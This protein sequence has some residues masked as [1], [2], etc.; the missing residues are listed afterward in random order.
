M[1][2]CDD[3]K[4]NPE[5]MVAFLSA[6]QT[7]RPLE[8]IEKHLLTVTLRRAALRFW[9]SRL[10]YH[11]AHN[12]ELTQQKNP[13]VFRQILLQHQQHNLEMIP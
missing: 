5:K 2:C 1:K 8:P 3:G 9:L 6:Y 11:H 10:T 7:L 4:I 12:G 13:D